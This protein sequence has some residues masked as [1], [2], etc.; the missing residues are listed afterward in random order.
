M[1]QKGLQ[2]EKFLKQAFLSY[3]CDLGFYCPELENGSLWLNK[4]KL[5]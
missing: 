5:K 1:W 2:G 3:L 4:T